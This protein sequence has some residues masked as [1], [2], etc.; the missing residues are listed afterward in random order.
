MRNVLVFGAS[1]GALIGV[2]LALA[3]H[4]ATLVCRAPT[5]DLINREGLRV[6]MP[7]KGRPGLV[8]V[9][10]RGLGGRVYATTHAEARPCDYDL[11]GVGKQGPD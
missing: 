4:R 8:E 9:R 1:Y 6:R 5:A 11:R 2:K 10:S 7:V 3:G